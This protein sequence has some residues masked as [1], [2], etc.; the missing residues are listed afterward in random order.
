MQLVDRRA[1]LRARVRIRQ[2][3]RE[4]QNHR[5][6]RVH[7]PKRHGYDLTR[8]SLLSELPRAPEYALSGPQHSLVDTGAAVD[9]D[10]DCA[11][12]VAH[13][14]FGP[15]AL[16]PPLR[17]LIR[18]ER[19]DRLRG[20]IAHAHDRAPSPL[21]VAVAHAHQSPGL[22]DIS[23][24]FFWIDGV[25]HERGS[26]VPRGVLQAHE[27]SLGVRHV[28]LDPIRLRG[29]LLELPLLPRNLSRVLKLVKRTLDDV[30]GVLL[31]AG[32]SQQVEYAVIRELELRHERRSGPAR[33]VHEILLVQ[34]LVE[35]QDARAPVVFSPAPRSARHLGVL[36]GLQHAH[37]LSVELFNFR[38]HAR[39]RG[40][41][42]THRERLR[43]EQALHEGFP[44]ENLDELLDDRE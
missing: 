31:A 7:E 40:H 27:L 42:Q 30:F 2:I 14:P 15:L 10:V 29:D 34:L 22:Q 17:R 24:Q 12:T 26:R 5:A 13:L 43:G 8:A 32:P 23:G 25:M 19:R 11:S 37:L 35:H 1:N 36:A 21:V 4:G 16:Q 38:E 41:V 9:Q 6:H 28:Q 44:E 3:P 39:S 33:H 20:K 18:F